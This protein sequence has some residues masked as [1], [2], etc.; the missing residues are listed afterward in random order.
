MH[1]LQR[2]LPQPSVLK[3]PSH[4]QILSYP[5]LYSICEEYCERTFNTKLNQTRYVNCCSPPCFSSFD[6]CRGAIFLCFHLLLL[7]LSS[8]KCNTEKPQLKREQFRAEIN[9]H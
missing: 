1:H 4:D 7:R 9:N 6:P 3:A 2:K 8:N 5:V